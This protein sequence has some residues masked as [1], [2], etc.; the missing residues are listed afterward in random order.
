[1]AKRVVATSPAEAA[2]AA[3]RA[4]LE[5]AHPERIPEFAHVV[6]SAAQRAAGAA[7]PR[8]LREA[9]RK[10]RDLFRKPIADAAERSAAV[11]QAL[12]L[13]APFAR[14]EYAARALAQ[15]PRVLAGLG[16]RRADQLAKRGMSTVE[17]LLYRLPAGYDDRRSLAGLGSLPVGAR[18]ANVTR[19]PTGSR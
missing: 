9:L 7:V 15:S 10:V 11:E 16:P 19:A 5:F 17:D 13:L 2:I 6:E 8:E 12:A 4:P 14:A 1:M 18:A 3:V